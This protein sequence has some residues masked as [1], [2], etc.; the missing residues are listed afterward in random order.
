MLSPVCMV[1]ISCMIS[2]V[3][4]QCMSACLPLYLILSDSSLH[5]F[6]MLSRAFYTL[7]DI[8]LLLFTAYLM[9]AVCYLPYKYNLLTACLQFDCFL[10]AYV[11]P[12]VIFLN[13]DGCLS[14]ICCLPVCWVSVSYIRFVLYASTLRQLSVCFPFL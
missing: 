13:C 1:L 2:S 11:C 9:S 6:S 7:P 5:S 10:S 14:V 3:S 12:I 4:L 8:C